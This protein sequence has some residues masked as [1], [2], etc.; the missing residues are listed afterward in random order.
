MRSPD[1]TWQAAPLERAE[2]VR[3]LG[4][5]GA[6]LWLTGLPAPGNPCWPGSSSA[7]S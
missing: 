5:A 4:Y 1:V 3:I 7:G 2:R 6:T